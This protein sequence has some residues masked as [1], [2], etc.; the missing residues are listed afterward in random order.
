MSYTTLCRSRLYG[1][2][3]L[4]QLPPTTILYMPCDVMMSIATTLR[5]YAS[6]II[7][8]GIE[9]IDSAW[10]ITYSLLRPSRCTVYCT[11]Q[12]E[13]GPEGW[14][15]G[16]KVKDDDD[17]LLRYSSLV[18][19]PCHYRHQYFHCVMWH[20]MFRGAEVCRWLAICRGVCE[21]VVGV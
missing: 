17:Y 9:G 16:N 2:T 14:L 11:V 10:I 8:Y 19:K 5:Y 13:C 20:P 6:P 21:C 7:R 4:F 1:T 3:T 12:R 15:Q 18:P